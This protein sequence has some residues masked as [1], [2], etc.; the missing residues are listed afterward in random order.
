MNLNI[1]KFFIFFPIVINSLKYFKEK[2]YVKYSNL[3]YSTKLHFYLTNYIIENVYFNSFINMTELI[4]E[5]SI[6]GEYIIIDNNMI[7]FNYKE[8]IEF[9]SNNALAIPF[10]E[11]QQYQKF[12]FL[13]QLKSNKL[14]ENKNIFF[15]PTNETS[16]I[17][18]YN[19][20]S[21]S[22]EGDIYYGGIDNDIIKNRDK[23]AININNSELI[24]NF[25]K[26][27]FEGF[28]DIYNIIGINNIII[29]P[30]PYNMLAPKSFIDYFNN[31]FLKKYYNNDSDCKSEKTTIYCK[32]KVVEKLPKLKIFFEKNK[33]LFI[34]IKYFFYLN[35]GYINSKERY[36]FFIL[37]QYNKYFRFGYVIMKNNITELNIDNKQIIFYGDYINNNSYNFFKN[38]KNI[39]YI[40]YIIIFVLNFIGI[41]NLIIFKFLNKKNY[42]LLLA[43]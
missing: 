32:V 23:L 16:E 10:F 27:L 40:S 25:N 42:K 22:I 37:K 17:N 6:L 39:I 7:H 26:I 19:G 13:N 5:K 33:F 4:N 8:F 24:I 21:D 20:L 35:T 3:Y 36:L 34:E 11:D 38:K 12:Y 30:S 1:Y 9:D 18:Y 15:I 43:Q 29:T 41:L 14:I 2:Y 31:T 28:E